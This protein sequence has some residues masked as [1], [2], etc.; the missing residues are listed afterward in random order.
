VLAP[1]LGLST[2]TA[3]D[4]LYKTAR[5]LLDRTACARQITFAVF[6]NVANSYIDILNMRRC[7]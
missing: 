2:A 7:A 6:A 4:Y 3:T 1:L 5:S